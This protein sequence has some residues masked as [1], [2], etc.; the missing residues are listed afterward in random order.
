MAWTTRHWRVLVL[1]IFVALL[2]SQIPARAIS[3]VLPEDVIVTGV[4]GTIWSGSAARAW[5]EIDQRPLMLGR[6]QW[7]I[8]PW[9]ILW[10]APLSLTSAWG[11]QVMRAQLGYR[12][13]GS[14]VLQEVSFTLNAQLLGTFLPL[15][16]GGTLSGEFAYLAIDQG[17][18]IDAEGVLRLQRGVWT[19]RSGSVLLGDYQ[20][21]FSS[22]D[23]AGSGT[24]G[25][26]KTLG[27][28][29][30]LSGDLSATLTGYQLAVQATGPVAR[31]ESF[32]QAMSIIA[33]PHQDGFS[34]SLAGQF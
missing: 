7:H 24:E 5:I 23:I 2:S 17:H 31:D 20:I 4:S 6:V 34:V 3:I 13:G 10:G 19:A 1:F 18:I 28:A 22:A 16:L 33:I 29:L 26:L 9:R 12:P 14:I 21:D 30:M 27:G 15:Y 11:Q 25:V 32:R 8:Q